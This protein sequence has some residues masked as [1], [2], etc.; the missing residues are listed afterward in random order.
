MVDLGRGEIM[1]E[2][3]E[4]TEIIKNVIEINTK[5]AL[6]YLVNNYSQELTIEDVNMIIKE[7]QWHDVDRMFLFV[8]MVNKNFDFATTKDVIRTFTDIVVAMEDSVKSYIFVNSVSKIVGNGSRILFKKSN[9][10]N[11]TGLIKTIYNS[12]NLE[13]VY[14]FYQLIDDEIKGKLFAPIVKIRLKKEKQQIH[15]KIEDLIAKEIAKWQSDGM[16]LKDGRFSFWDEFEKVEWFLKRYQLFLTPANIN[17]IRELIKKLIKEK[18]PSAIYDEESFENLAS[19]N[20]ILSQKLENLIIYILGNNAEGFTDVITL[21]D[22]PLRNSD[23]LGYKNLDYDVLGEY[24][25]TKIENAQLRLEI[26]MSY[27]KHFK[28]QNSNFPDFCLKIENALIKG[29]T[30]GGRDILKYFYISV[31]RQSQFNDYFNSNKFEEHL[32]MLGT[33]E[34]IADLINIQPKTVS[35]PQMEEKIFALDEADI[36]KLLDQILWN[37]SLI[38]DSSKLEEWER[39]YCK[40]GTALQIVVFLTI[41]NRNERM[42][43][44]N[45]A[46]CIEILFSK[47][48]DKAELPKI[49]Y[50]LMEITNVDLI[51]LK[52][53]L[54]VTGNKEYIEK[55]YN[56]SLIQGR[57]LEQLLPR[58]LAQ[59]PYEYSYKPRK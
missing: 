58:P 11:A 53:Q 17:N 59:A 12:D 49:I 9:K 39:L 4:L 57:Y 32:L 26:I 13:K 56:N 14:Q 15:S 10:I 51:K 7:Y 42:D 50:Y 41:V 19:Q 21:L 31:F 1:V 45:L 16:A 20:K 22:I 48:S 47:I 43:E 36:L 40:L 37:K 8:K 18:L 46:N 35:V 33:K 54:L 29:Y 2:K 38:K 27:I 28:S 30:R 52:E 44:I 6:E 5:G 25:I 24:I 34:S 3:K 23:Y 55:F